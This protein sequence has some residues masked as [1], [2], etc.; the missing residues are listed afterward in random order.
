M[1][2]KLATTAGLDFTRL[3]LQD[4][5]FFCSANDDVAYRLH[6]LI[7]GHVLGALVL[8]TDGSNAQ[9]ELPSDVI[10]AVGFDDD[11]ALLPVTLTGFAGYRLLQ[12]YFAFPQRFLF[13]DMVGLGPALR[14]LGGN[15]AEI[16]LLFSR[17][18]SS[19]QQVVDTQA[20]ELNCV[21]AIN[22]FEQRCDRIQ[23]T[24]QLA[25]PA[26]WSDWITYT[27]G[28]NP[29]RFLDGAA[30]SNRLYRVVSP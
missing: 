2:I 27:Q 28:T 13:F 25:S 22:L 19:L 15:E 7:C 24:P 6:E 21:P 12:E 9:Q 5:R 4:L 3:S 18:D 10:R 20:L 23:V 26:V 16:V 14:A 17:G 11:Q 29:V 1:R 8:P 30:G